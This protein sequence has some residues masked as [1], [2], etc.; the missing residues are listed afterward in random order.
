MDSF[1][2]RVC[3]FIRDNDLLR[4][5][6]AVTAGFSGGADSMC[7]LA[8]LKELEA[9]LGITVQAV[10]INHQL[11]G[12]EADRDEDFC[13]RAAG[14]L[15]ADFAA[16]RVDVRGY[17][18]ERGL[19]EEEAGR[20]LRYRALLAHA[21]RF[22]KA[23]R[24]AQEA[25]PSGK[26]GPSRRVILAVAHHADDQAETI[27]FNLL[28]GSGLKGLSGMQPVRGSIVRPLLCVSRAEILAY[29]ERK[30]LSYT[31]DSTNAENDHTRNR[32]RNLILPAMKELVNVRAAEHIGAAGKLAGEADKYLEAE[33]ARFLDEAAC[34]A[35]AA[36]AAGS[37]RQPAS[38]P[39]TDRLALN[40]VLLKEKAPILRRY[41]II[42]ALRRMQVPL[43]DWGEKHLQDIDA[44]LFAGKGYHTDLPGGVYTE[45]AYRETFL[46]VPRRS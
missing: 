29:L 34:A 16:E 37:F 1:T 2:N 11:R 46:H 45:N 21:Q 35:A 3:K 33:A 22:G 9:L 17:A 19:G 14:Q 36:E 4:R 10:H 6:D 32:I 18:A 25:P 44:A 7:L 42:E 43:K 20:E 40:Q 28:R 41:V 13:R 39:Q 26:A 38:S 5:G 31:V 27:L 8:V 15:G 23:E 30:A 12:A 24:S